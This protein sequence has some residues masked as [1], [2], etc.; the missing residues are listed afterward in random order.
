LRKV[1]SFCATRKMI[2]GVVAR[3]TGFSLYSK[4]DEIKEGFIHYSGGIRI[5]VAGKGVADRG[6][7]SGFSEITSVNI[8]LP[9]EM[10]GCSKKLAPILAD[11]D[12]T[13]IVSPPFAGKTT[14]IRDMIRVLAKTYDVAVVD[15]R[16]EISGGGESVYDIGIL[17]DIIQNVPK[18]LIVE[19]L[20]RSMSPEIIVLDELSPYKDMKVIEEISRS[21]IKLLASIHSS[22]IE[23]LVSALPDIPRHFTY[24]VLLGNKPCIGSIQSIVRFRSD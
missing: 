19:G 23:R 21:G 24:G 11:F 13:I 7:L 12:N 14:L 15:E 2:D 8:R 20:I 3:A 17:T 16:C 5:G 1:L 6:T 10:I 18:T 9:H 4:Q 22:N